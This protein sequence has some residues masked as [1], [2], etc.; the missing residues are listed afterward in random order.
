MCIKQFFDE[1][2]NKRK[3]MLQRGVKTIESI[4]A[5]EIKNTKSIIKQY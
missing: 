2:N 1:F 5:G 3:F 4:R